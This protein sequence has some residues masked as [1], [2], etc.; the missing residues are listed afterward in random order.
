M[1][2]IILVVSAITGQLATG[3][4]AALVAWPTLLMAAEL[5]LILGIARALGGVGHCCRRSSSEIHRQFI[6]AA[7]RW[8]FALKF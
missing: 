4:T 3:E 7:A 5:A 1:A 2:A 8:I 6:T